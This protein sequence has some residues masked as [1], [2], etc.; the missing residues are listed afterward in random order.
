MSNTDKVPSSMGNRYLLPD[1]NR[2]AGIIHSRNI[3]LGF[4][5]P[6]SVRP[7]DGMLA[8]V[9]GE[10][11]E[12]LEEW[13]DGRR[14]D[15]TYWSIRETGSEEYELSDALQMIEGR[16]HIRNYDYEFR[17]NDNSVKPWLL[18]TPELLRTMPN[19]IRHLKPE[20]IPS[21][22]ADIIIR[23]LDIC[24][25]NGI[26]IAAAIADKMAFNETRPYRHGGKQS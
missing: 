24:A 13:R 19:M 17:G 10:V 25:A 7:F 1:L 22:L 20:G 15:E 16:L 4:Y 8:N 12:A 21:E 5:E 14:V 26:D 11:S 18:M 23:V 6:D 9:H 2:L 3:R